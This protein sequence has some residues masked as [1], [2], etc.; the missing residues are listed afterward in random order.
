[1]HFS[2]SL[3]LTESVVLCA[4][5]TL[6]SLCCQATLWCWE[7]TPMFK[8]C[9]HMCF[10]SCSKPCVD[11]SFRLNCSPPKIVPCYFTESLG[12]H[13]RLLGWK[14]EKI[15]AAEFVLLCK[16]RDNLSPSQIFS[17]LCITYKSSQK[18]CIREKQWTSSYY[19]S[20]ENL[21]FYFSYQ[22]DSAFWM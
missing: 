6:C 9:L 4:P 10:W 16:E 22:W 2:P 21:F 17:L 1:M 14:A 15:Y 3:F 13:T 19:F 11:N 7:V 8:P 12:P 18:H 5:L 20:I